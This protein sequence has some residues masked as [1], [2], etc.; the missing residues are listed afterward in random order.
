MKPANVV[1]DPQGYPK[2]T[3][4]GLSKQGIN[5]NITKSFCGS[6]AY[7]APEVLNKQGHTRMIDW[8][9]LGL[10]IFELLTGAPPYYNH[11]R[12]TLF[13]NI[14]KATLKFPNYVSPNA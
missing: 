14:K 3:D 1:I 12:E 8:Y 10:L 5:N 11:S 4:F 9:L 13:E 2:L 7:L 6:I